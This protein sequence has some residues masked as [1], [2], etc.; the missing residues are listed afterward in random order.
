M[1]EMIAFFMTLDGTWQHMTVLPYDIS[2]LQQKL[3]PNH[4]PQ[5]LN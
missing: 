4:F 2:S 5:I 1:T 3:A